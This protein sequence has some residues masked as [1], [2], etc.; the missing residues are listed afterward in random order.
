MVK[1]LTKSNTNNAIVEINTSTNP[2]LKYT[3]LITNKI[4]HNLAAIDFSMLTFNGYLS[5]LC[6]KK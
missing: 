3:P 5:M 4:T 2:I 6:F 1:A